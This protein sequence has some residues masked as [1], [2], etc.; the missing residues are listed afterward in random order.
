M[1]LLEIKLWKL[2]YGMS[3]GINRTFHVVAPDPITAIKMG[4]E[5]MSTWKSDFNI[6]CFVSIQLEHDNVIMEV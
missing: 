2:V 1:T 4:D 3:A 5:W 6:P